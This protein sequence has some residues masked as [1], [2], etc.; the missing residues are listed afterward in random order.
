M[1]APAPEPEPVPA[2]EPEADPEPEP[3]PT[4]DAPA[5]QDLDGLESPAERDK[6]IEDD[7]LEIPAFLRRQAN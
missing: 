2:P 7:L 3:E 4:V 6:G 1:S 5:Q